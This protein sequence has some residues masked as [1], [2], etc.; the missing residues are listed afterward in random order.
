MH[1]HCFVIEG[2]DLAALLAAL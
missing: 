2:S 1:T